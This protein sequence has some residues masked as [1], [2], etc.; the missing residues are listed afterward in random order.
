MVVHL[1]PETE[2]RLQQLAA[3]TGRPP[4]DLL[5][6]AMAGYLGEL[7][8]LRGH[9]DGRYDQIKSGQVKPIDGDEA[10][11][12]LRRKNKTRRGS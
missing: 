8:Q 12:R 10:F 9:L 4:E 5:E 7:T 6:D 1:K 2:S 11:A 3:K